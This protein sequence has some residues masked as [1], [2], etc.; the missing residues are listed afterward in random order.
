MVELKEGLCTL[1]AVQNVFLYFHCKLSLR[2]SS[3]M[4]SMKIKLLFD[5]DQDRY[6]HMRVVSLLS[7]VQNRLNHSCTIARP[8]KESVGFAQ[9][10]SRLSG[11]PEEAALLHHRPRRR[12][13]VHAPCGQRARR[14]A[15]EGSLSAPLTRCSSC[16][17]ESWN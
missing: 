10:V 14:G 5:E 9:V 6:F 7:S 13:L 15:E 16:C 11:G 8:A 17:Q 1:N 2:P 12:L 3:D 4:R